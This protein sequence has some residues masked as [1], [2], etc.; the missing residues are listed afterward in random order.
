MLDRSAGVNS[1]F[2]VLVGN[3]CACLAIGPDILN[4]KSIDDR[5]QSTNMIGMG[6]SSDNGLQGTLYVLLQ[7]VNYARGLLTAIYQNF[8]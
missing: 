1:I 4:G 5:N 2:K 6:M 8:G 3:R 7:K